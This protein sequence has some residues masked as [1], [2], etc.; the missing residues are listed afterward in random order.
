MY[1]RK[2]KNVNEQET[3]S[4]DLYDSDTIDKIN[5]LDIFSSKEKL[6]H[7]ETRDLIQFRIEAL[8]GDNPKRSDVMYF[9]AFLDSYSDNFKGSWN[10][11]KYNGRA[12]EFYTYAGFGR[13]ISLIK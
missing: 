6:N 3:E 7:R 1:G 4:Y 8:N 11:F 5:A 10:K 13:D 12:E 2:G 9:R